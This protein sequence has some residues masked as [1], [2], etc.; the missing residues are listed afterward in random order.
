MTE[1]QVMTYL[2]HLNTLITTLET[3]PFP[4]IAS[5]AGAAMGGG[6]ELILG[7][8]VRICSPEAVFGL[9]ETRLGVIPGAGTGC[10]EK[11]CPL[12]VNLKFLLG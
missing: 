5:V 8:D 7:C 10:P 6:L 12:S 3:L 1:D 9:P 2:D 4:V 11:L